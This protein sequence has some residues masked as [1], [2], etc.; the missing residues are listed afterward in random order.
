M[1]K[2][3]SQAVILMLCTIFSLAMLFSQVQ[4]KTRI[5]QY[6][7]VKTSD[8]YNS[9]SLHKHKI[10]T[11]AINN[12][13]TTSSSRS[14]SM[15]RVKFDGKTGYV[16]RNNLATKPKSVKFYVTKTTHL[17]NSTKS[18]KR[19][20]TTIQINNSL[21]TTSPL[22][23]SYYEVRYGKQTGYVYKTDLS[24]QPKNVK[25]Y[26]V[27]TAY[28]Y[29]ST[30]NN[31]RSVATI[32]VNNSL[33]TTSPL[34]SNMYQVQY[35]NHK[36]YVLKTN[37]STK[38]TVVNF[39]TI[40][41]SILYNSTAKNKREC[42]SIG[43]DEPL[44]TTSPLSSFMFQVSYNNQK[45]Y[46]YAASLGKSPVNYSDSYGVSLITRYEMLQIPN[47]QLYSQ[48]KVPNFDSENIN[49]I[50]S[51]TEEKLGSTTPVAMDVWDSWPLLN[52]DGTLATYDGYHLV[53]AMA[54]APN[55]SENYIYLFYQKVGDNSLDAW[56]NAG[57]IF[58]GENANEY[59]LPNDKYLATQA[60][61]WSGSAVLTAGGNVRLFYTDRQP[62]DPANK[63]YGDQ[64]LTTAQVNIDTTKDS[65]GILSVKNLTGLKSLFA[66]D[67]KL[68]QT[69]DQGANVN[70]DD[71]CLRDPHY[72]EDNDGTKYLVFEGNTGTDDG[73][74]G[75]PSLYNQAY[76]GGNN[77]FF[78]NEQKSLL[79]GSEKGYASLANGAIGLVKLDSNY[80]VVGVEKPLI[81]SN[82]VSDEIERP[83]IFQLNGKWY[84]FTVTRGNRFASPLFT[85]NM[86]Y[87]LG[88]VADHLQ[89]P[90]LPLN[91]TGLVLA[92]HEALDSRTFT[93]SYFNVLPDIKNLK[94]NGG[95][96]N[97]VITGYM[98]NRGLPGND[99]STF[100]PS[101]LLTIDG[102]KTSVRSQDILNQGQLTVDNASAAPVSSGGTGTGN[103]SG[104]SNSSG[105]S[106]G[107]SY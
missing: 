8:L 65:Q 42:S 47:Q 70:G 48:F 7:V 38:P 73:Y 103:S 30:N 33:N 66:G 68:Y 27:K 100:A 92:S 84:L 61:E 54:G 99:R 9:T 24:A 53:F 59:A 6:Y 25:F 57:R 26:V 77:T 41:A 101:F 34:S 62:W 75:E 91:G 60:E 36:G 44:S 35:G 1:K 94:T 11:I 67:G 5:Y 31:K 105:D 22:S 50:P 49:N 14:S 88:F 98:T 64:I 87:M 104:S 107:S 39:Y 18:N 17:Y 19:S 96:T 55:S 93:Y 71:H 37:L 40:K 51:A 106:S 82:L 43:I 89:G 16:Y 63:F 78:K 81:V 13:L 12:R 80:N 86:V 20:L 85:N 69:A 23:S 58:K 28:L 95:P 76:Y 56:K 2:L 4:A 79:S 52:T 45:G 83:N 15:Y 46:V 72:I 102:D 32:Q 29:N 74:Q 21:F 10:S 3:V 97:V 90:Y